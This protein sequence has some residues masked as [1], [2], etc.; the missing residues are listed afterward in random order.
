MNRAK[1]ERNYY[2]INI[3]NAVEDGKRNPNTIGS[4]ILFKSFESSAHIIYD[5]AQNVQVP[6]L[7]QQIGSLF[8]KSLQ[9]VH[10]FGVCN[11]GNF[12]HTE[13]INFVINEGEMPDDGKQ[14][15]GTNCTLS[16]VWHAI[17]KYN[18]G[19]KKLVIT[20]DNCVGQNKNN[21]FL[22]FYS[23]LINHGLYEEVELNFMIPKY[24]K[25]I[26]DS[27]FGLIKI[28]YQKSKV[29][30]VD[31]IVSIINHSTTVHLNT[32]QHYLNGEGFQYYDFKNYFQMFKKL[33]NI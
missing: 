27:C 32:S 30:T 8:F 22:F 1:E 17:Q 7:S 19:E 3:K 29:N 18:R 12:S 23:W 5:W 24:T 4:Q 25:F 11:T 2:N 9:K 33:P 28:L 20:C 21:F 6:Y 10:L 26:C 14:E 16:L 15:K 31:N 13:Q